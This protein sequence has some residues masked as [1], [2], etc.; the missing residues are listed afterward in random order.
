MQVRHDGRIQTHS[1]VAGGLDEP[2]AIV[3]RS[4]EIEG[5]GPSSGAKLAAPLG[6][7]EFFD[8]AG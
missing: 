7:A 6:S 2:P 5:L 8:H 3:G 4:A 1:G